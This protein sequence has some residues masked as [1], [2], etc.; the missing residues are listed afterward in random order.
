LPS[1][2]E[3]FCVSTAHSRIAPSAALDEVR[4]ATVALILI[5]QLDAP[6][7]TGAWRARCGC[8]ASR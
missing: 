7:V 3:K 5:K 1:A 8:T 2:P 4:L 6:S